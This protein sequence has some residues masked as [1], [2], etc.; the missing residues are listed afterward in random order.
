[1]LEGGLIVD[2]GRLDAFQT[3][4]TEEQ[5][6]K[7]ASITRRWGVMLTGLGTL[8]ESAMEQLV[9]E[10]KE[11]IGLPFRVDQMPGAFT[12]KTPYSRTIHCSH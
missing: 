8:I 12:I 9:L 1:M 7:L 10:F 4:L 11:S 2:V 5:K 3:K 6:Q